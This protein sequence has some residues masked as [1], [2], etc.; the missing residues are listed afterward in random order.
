MPQNSNSI[1]FQSVLDALVENGK[2]FPASY[3]TRFSDIQSSDLALLKKTWEDVKPKRRLNLVED[4]I[5]FN[6][7][8][9]IACF[10]DVA[11]F[12]LT[13][14]DARVRTAA[15]RLLRE[16]EDPRIVERLI[17]LLEKDKQL[18]VRAAAAGG[19]GPFVLLGELDKISAEK[20]AH[21]ERVLLS[22]I[23]GTDDDLVRRSALEAMGYSSRKEMVNLI[24]EAFE[25]NDP[26]WVAS[27]LVA[28]GRSASDEWEMH[29]LRSLFHPDPVV[30]I[31][32][33]RAAGSLNLTR[34]VEPL[35]ELLDAGESNKELRFAA[36]WALS[37]I[38]GEKANAALESLLDN[39]ATDEEADFIEDAIDNIGYG[40]SS[41]G[42]DFLDLDDLRQNA[43]TYQDSDDEL[44]EEDELDEEGYGNDD[45]DQEPPSEQSA[46]YDYD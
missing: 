19:L 9:T 25:E 41:L 29:I 23:T 39:A 27:S 40:D 16:S 6:E 7:K 46:R 10:D 42:L 37:E 36:I 26:D 35:L 4:L 17:K 43:S 21:I 18:I 12:F 14:D 28:M 22:R 38:G 5:K 15:I 44:Y 11:V 13:D 33:I 31:E 24:S 20:L 32:A 30:R 1:P 3:L 34:A 8:T 2:P 45:Y